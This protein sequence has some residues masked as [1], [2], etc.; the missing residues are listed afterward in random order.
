VFILFRK[1]TARAAGRLRP[2]VLASAAALST[3]PSAPSPGPSC[4]IKTVAGCVRHMGVQ[5]GLHRRFM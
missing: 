3:A 1:L 4:E 5:F 2:L